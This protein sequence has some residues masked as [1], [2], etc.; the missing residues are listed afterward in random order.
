MF[1]E[2]KLNTV[3][4]LII[5][6]TAR[7]SA[8]ATGQLIETLFETL[9]PISTLSLHSGHTS[10]SQLHPQ[11]LFKR[12][13]LYSV[14]KAVKNFQPDVF[15]VRPALKPLV[16]NFFAFV[17]ISV[18][19]PKLIVHV[20]D[21]EANDKTNGGLFRRFLFSHYLRWLLRRADKVFSISPGMREA[22]LDRYS[23]DS[24]PLSNIPVIRPSASTK[25]LRLRG[26]IKIGYFGSLDVRMNLRCVDEIC[27][28]VDKL[29]NTELSVELDIFTRPIYQE[30]A[31]AG[32]RFKHT[33]IHPYVP[34]DSYFDILRD[35]D[36]LLIAYNFDP[37]T[38]EY[39][40]FSIANKLA[41]YLS[42][43]VPTLVVGPEAI[44]TVAHCK[45]HEIGTTISNGY[46]VLE[47]EI[48]RFVN[49]LKRGEVQQSGME[50]RHRDA[51]GLDV[52]L[53]EWRSA[54]KAVDSSHTPTNR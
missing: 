17:L 12:N 47:E 41:D 26:E 21:D 24:Q 35:Y 40:R 39:C 3:R 36:A 5:S 43:G 48:G 44:E 16:F 42:V 50:E 20:M 25:R 19:N 7:G 8:S 31:K 13:R 27:A 32:F 9:T 11:L 1:V 15:Y 22:F 54:F 30:W 18:F 10:V 29:N 2:E 53:D 49:Q 51:L 23:C 37:V 6:V 52:A 38:V 33:K 4:V 14:Y 45:R 28:V 34:L 46:K